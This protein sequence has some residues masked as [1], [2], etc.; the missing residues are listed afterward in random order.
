MGL[1]AKVGILALC[2]GVLI[3]AV[4]F[5]RDHRRSIGRRLGS[6][7]VLSSVLSTGSPAQRLV[8]PPTGVGVNLTHVRYYSDDRQFAN[9]VIG[10]EWKI[11]APRA[12]NAPAV[13]PEVD[14][15][16]NLLRLPAGA[17]AGRRLTMPDTGPR[18]EEFVCSYS[19]EGNVSIRGSA[20]MIG[21][22]QGRLRFMAIQNWQKPPSIFFSIDSMNA[23]HP[24]RDV[25]C[26][27]A[28]M[29]HNLRFAPTF[30]SELKG[31]KVLRFMDWQNTNANQ[32]VAWGQRRKPTSSETD[33]DGISIEDMM[34][35]TNAVGADPWFSMP[36]NADAAYVEGF[37]KRVHDLL[38]PG[39]KVYVEVGNEVWNW[40]FSSTKQASREGQAKGLSAD[41]G[42][43]RLFRYAERTVEVMRIWERVFADRKGLV[44]VAATQNTLPA[45]VRQVLGYKDT[46]AHIDAVATAPYF[47]VRMGREPEAA[48][49]DSVFRLLDARVDEA[50]GKAK[51][52]KAEAA[53]FGKRYIAYEGGQHVAGKGKGGDLALMQQVQ[54]DP[55]M[56]GLY[57]KYLDGWKAQIG[58]VLC[59]LTSIARINEAGGWGLRE[60]TGAPL[61]ESPKQR[62]VS[63][64]L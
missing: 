43:A 41:A 31:Y 23:A 33:A 17:R 64:A 63:E 45:Q 32:A 59:L 12:G 53:A 16:G 46:A 5:L 48:D 20:R 39:R 11:S 6:V 29:P 58:D 42:K 50:L 36:W 14:P 57:K 22:S 21:Q 35:V 62:A 49:V 51:S 55:R 40:S 44:R 26:R 18:G 24:I 61:D 13:D 4:L 2:A 47:P 60:H 38:P 54:R 34:E 52:N 28:S 8:V 15:D 1:A 10:A 7:A 30:I 3:L 19:G 27:E 25:D 9:L 37:A 56:Y